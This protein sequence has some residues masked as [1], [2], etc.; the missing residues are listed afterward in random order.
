MTIRYPHAKTMYL[1]PISHHTQLKMDHSKTLR[2][3]HR[4]H[5]CDLRLGKDFLGVTLQAQGDRSKNRKL[6][7]IKIKNNSA[8]KVT[9]KKVKIQFRE[10]EKIFVN[11][12][13]L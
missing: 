11:H 5:L 8:S 3:K 2:R 12:V 1:D 13:S 6:V 4:T 9:I 10:R 7:F